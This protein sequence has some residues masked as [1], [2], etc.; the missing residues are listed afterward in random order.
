MYI[1]EAH[2]INMEDCKEITRKV[3]FDGQFLENEKECYLYAMSKAYNMKEENECLASVEF[4]A[5]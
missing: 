1:F 2:F 4:I 3:E 5:C